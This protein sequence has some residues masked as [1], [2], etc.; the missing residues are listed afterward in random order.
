MNA[1]ELISAL[2]EMVSKHGN[3]EV[4]FFN[5]DYYRHVDVITLQ[6]ID[7]EFTRLELE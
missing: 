7:G 4:V 5:G 1:L 3:Q 2:V 6:S